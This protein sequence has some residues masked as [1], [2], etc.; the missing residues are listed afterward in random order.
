MKR[1]NTNLRDQGLYYVFTGIWPLLHIKSFAKFSG[2]KPDPFQTRVTGM[3]FTAIGLVLIVASRKRRPEGE[4]VLLSAAS[5]GAAMVSTISHKRKNFGLL[6]DLI[7]EGMYAYIS[8]QELRRRARKRF[9]P[10]SPLP[11]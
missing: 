5:A 9:S 8:V 2:K 1:V 10:S 11:L 7:P 3:L 6:M 4:A